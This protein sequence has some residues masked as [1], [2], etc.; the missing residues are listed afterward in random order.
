[1]CKMFYSFYFKKTN[2]QKKNPENTKT[3]VT[4]VKI[5]VGFKCSITFIR[6]GNCND[7]GRSSQKQK[8]CACV[9]ARAYVRPFSGGS[10]RHA[11]GFLQVEFSC[12]SG[13]C[14][15]RQAD[16]AMAKKFK[17]SCRARLLNRGKK[18]NQSCHYKITFNKLMY[19]RMHLSA[20]NTEPENIYP[21][22]FLG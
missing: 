3:L 5:R 7:K 4:K 11:E 8:V 13:F 12:R 6:Y 2:K 15:L 14:W 18:K 9:C 17:S 21:P 16:T 20:C 19:L 22:L 1:M 10:W